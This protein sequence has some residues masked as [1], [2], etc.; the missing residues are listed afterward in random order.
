VHV[1]KARQGMDIGMHID[2]Y[3]LIAEE[4]DSGSYDKGL[5]AKAFALGNANPEQQKILYAQYRLEQL[6][7]VTPLV[8]EGSP[9]KARTDNSSPIIVLAISIN[10][11]SVGWLLFAPSIP[12]AVLF[13]IGLGLLMWGT[14]K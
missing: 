8:V 13:S 2:Q 4:I 1:N 5:W 14:S 6:R 12:A 11:V 10:L 9:G 7:P 3:Q